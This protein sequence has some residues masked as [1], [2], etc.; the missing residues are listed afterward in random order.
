MCPRPPTRPWV[1]F[2]PNTPLSDAGWRIEP[3]MSLPT[4]A[5]VNPQAIE[6]A[7]AATGK[8]G[9]IQLTSV[10]CKLT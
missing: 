7:A 4:S 2:N 6:A 8:G 3:P 10:H 1:V 5:V 9:T